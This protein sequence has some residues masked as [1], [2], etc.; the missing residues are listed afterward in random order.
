MSN[1]GE[2]LLSAIG[3]PQTHNNCPPRFP[4]C[5]RRLKKAALQAIQLVGP[6]LTFHHRI[7]RPASPVSRLNCPCPQPKQ[8]WW[9]YNIIPFLLGTSDRNAPSTPSFK[10]HP[11]LRG[12]P[13][14][15]HRHWAV[16]VC[17]CLSVF[18]FGCQS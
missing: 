13:E 3:L 1:D 12:T 11:I 18:L 5:Q 8:E 16:C 15:G 4:S 6:T 7:H 17:V 9:A 2:L 10:H 14:V